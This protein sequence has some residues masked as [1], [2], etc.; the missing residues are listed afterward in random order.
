MCNS[1][2]LEELTPSG[3]IVSWGAEPRSG[4]QNPRVGLQKLVIL[5]LCMARSF[6][7]LM[8]DVLNVRGSAHS[9]LLREEG[10]SEPRSSLRSREHDLSHSG[11]WDKLERKRAELAN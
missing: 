8:W 2:I 5:S 6:W 4:G 1:V 11:C 7:N 10:K 9:V 3:T